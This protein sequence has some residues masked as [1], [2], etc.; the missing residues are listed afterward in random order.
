MRNLTM[1]VV[2][3][4]VD[5]TAQIYA[6]SSHSVLKIENWYPPLACVNVPNGIFHTFDSV[7]CVRVFFSKIQMDR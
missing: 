6:M 1:D 7:F 4:V 5:R 3:V 2:R